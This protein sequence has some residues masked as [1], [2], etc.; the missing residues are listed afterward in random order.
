MKLMMVQ[1]KVLDLIIQNEGGNDLMEC[2]Y[3]DVSLD[4]I[5]TFVSFNDRKVPG[6]MKQVTVDVCQDTD[7]EY[8]YMDS[9]GESDKSSSSLD[10][11]HSLPVRISVE[12]FYVRFEDCRKAPRIEN[13][14]NLQNIF[15]TGL[16]IIFCFYYFLHLPRH[17]CLQ[18]QPNL[19]NLLTQNI[20][21]SCTCINNPFKT[22]NQF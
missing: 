20:S 17:L 5:P 11:A 16:A 21:F 12:D 14:H 4:A 15:H 3:G 6:D 2:C 22:E 7:L 18:H 19:L 10:S 9:D 1:E 8:N 13:L